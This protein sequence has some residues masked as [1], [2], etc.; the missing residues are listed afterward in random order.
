MVAAV[1]CW[2]VLRG[3]RLV[4]ASDGPVFGSTG[5]RRG[6][7]TA[8]AG[9]AATAAPPG[10]HGLALNRWGQ[11]AHYREAGSSHLTCC[12]PSGRWRLPKL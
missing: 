5:A 8:A 1:Q 7:G 6:P 12:M 11:A 10:S 3:R 2:P 9:R 4:R